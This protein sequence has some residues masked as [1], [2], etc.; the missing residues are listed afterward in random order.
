[1]ESGNPKTLGGNVALSHEISEILSPFNAWRPIPKPS[2]PGLEELAI[3][4]VFWQPTSGIRLC[5]FDEAQIRACMSDPLK[6]DWWAHLQHDFRP[7]LWDALTGTHVWPALAWDRLTNELKASCWNAIKEALG[8]LPYGTGHRA[9][10]W[11]S[12]FYACGF[13]Y[14]KNWDLAAKLTQS[15]RLWLNGTFPI[16][17]DAEGRLIIATAD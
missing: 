12:L 17:F 4:S 3:R 5:P 10:L 6:D 13:A 2:T 7:A 14:V 11:N 1:V 9:S 15:H 8:G 16:G